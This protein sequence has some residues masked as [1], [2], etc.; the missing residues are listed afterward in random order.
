M[1]GGWSRLDESPLA[2][3]WSWY[4]GRYAYHSPTQTWHYFSYNG[5]HWCV[6]LSTGVW[7]VF[8]T[9]PAGDYL[10]IDLSA[11][12]D[13][14]AYPIQYH[15]T[16]AD[17]PDGVAHD[18]YKTTHLL[19]RRIPAGAFT[20]GSPVGELTRDPLRE[21][22]RQVTLTKDVYIGVFEVTQR[23]WERVM[24]AWPSFFRTVGDRDARPVEQV[25]YQHIRE[26]PANSAISPNWPQSSQVHADSFMGRLRAKS[27]LSTL[28]LPTEAQW[29]YACRAGTTSA[30]NSGRQL[31]AENACPNMAEVGRY[32]HNG[33]SGFTQDG[34]TD[35][36][37][38][39]VGSY[40]PNAWGLYDMHG[41]VWELCLDWYTDSPTG[42]VDPAGAAS[43]VFRAVRGGGWSYPAWSC[44]SACR[45][46]SDPSYRIYYYGF[47]LARTVP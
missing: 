27:G 41:N 38:A 6:N 1:T 33:G 31:T 42:S 5:R 47:R 36:G 21:A 4:A 20:V 28:D 17:V 7:S 44:R 29:E 39:K 3:G 19:L 10:V 26:N 43:G 24:G 35:V 11:G 12:P 30:L 22:Q 40:L 34:G 15:P 13:A 46:I 2:Q 32:W 37:T 45:I 18:R 25:S 16:P 9:A 8:T 14:S 23:Q